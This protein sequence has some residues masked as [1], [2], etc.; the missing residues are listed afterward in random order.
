MQY[1]R[2]MA[3]YRGSRKHILDW[4]ES[5]TFLDQ[6]TTLLQP[7]GALPQMGTWLP[8][9]WKDPGEARLETYGPRHLPTATG[10]SDLKRWWI[11]YNGTTPNWDLAATGEFAGKSGIILVEAK[12]NVSELKATGKVPQ[13][14]STRESCQNHLRIGAAIAQAQEGLSAVIPGIKISIDTHYQLSN[15]LAFAWKLASLGVPTV[16]MYLGFVGDKGISDAGESLHDSDHWRRVFLA[17]A[18]GVAPRESFDRM[19]LINETPM[20]ILIRS[21][22]VLQQSLSRAEFLQARRAA[23]SC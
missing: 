3:I 23:P 14:N 13:P 20:W 11:R 4:V 2:T 16:L 17:H 19:I 1:I 5:E 12:A 6:L 15:R 8:L 10:W 18:A 9:G 21:Q 7:T 22:S